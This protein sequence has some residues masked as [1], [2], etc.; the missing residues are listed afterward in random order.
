MV[1]D[2]MARRTDG[3]SVRVARDVLS[4][5]ARV[6]VVIPDG[7]ADLAHILEHRGRRRTVVVGDDRALHRVVE[8]LHQ[9]GELG[10]A[11]LALIPVGAPERLRLARAVGVPAEAAPAARAALR[12][13]PRRLDLVV[14]DEGGV[15][16]GSAVIRPVRARLGA[17]TGLTGRTGLTGLTARHGGMRVAADGAAIGPSARTIRLLGT[18]DARLDDGLME[19]AVRQR[20]GARPVRVR[21]RQIRVWGEEFSYEADTWRIGPVGSRT[22][23]VLPGA[24][25]VSVPVPVR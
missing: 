19:V 11:G 5:A 18:D 4:A 23:T 12:G 20:A 22:W 15:V 2:P 7:P 21:A 3:E 16:L 24:W 25:A 1:I 13:V 6:K 17:L 10:G 14:D 9:R 8:L